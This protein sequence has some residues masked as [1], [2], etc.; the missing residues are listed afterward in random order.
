MYLFAC[1]TMGRQWEEGVFLCDDVMDG[2]D[3]AS[4]VLGIP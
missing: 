2:I 3:Y 1:H 4:W